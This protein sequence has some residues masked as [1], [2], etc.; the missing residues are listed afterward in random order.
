VPK[1]TQQAADVGD[2]HA[3]AEERRPD[4]SPAT[5]AEQLE[6]AQVEDE[7]TVEAGIVDIA[8]IL[9]AP[10]VTVVCSSL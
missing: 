1:A 8:S 3:S 5:R 4:P 6:E 7:A 9:G 10:T 2:S